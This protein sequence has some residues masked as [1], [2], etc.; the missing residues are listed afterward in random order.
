VIY[1]A[2][3]SECRRYRYIWRHTWDV[4]LP[5]LVVIG[6]NASIADEQRK[7]PTVTRCVNFASAWG[8]GSL[9]M[10][11]LFAFRAT[12]PNAMKAE[13][14][15]IGEENNQTLIDVCGNVHH[16][17]GGRI[18]AAWGNHGTH[19]NRS[20]DVTQLLCQNARVPLWALRVTKANQPQHPLYLPADTQPF[21][22]K[23][24]SDDR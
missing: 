8:L 23:E 22:W 15:P 13:A 9:W 21:K 6:L 20:R 10:L 7:D 17:D 18:L 19:L 2:I 5:A 4:S 3:F 11:N 14:R 1:D 24:S 12:D 16:L